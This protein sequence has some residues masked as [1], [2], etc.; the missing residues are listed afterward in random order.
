MMKMPIFIV[1]MLI[2]ISACH[3]PKEY[4]EFVTIPGQTWNS[5]NILHFNVNITDTTTAQNILISVRN[6]G[7]YAYS[8]LYLFVNA[9]S[10]NGSVARDTV[11]IMLADER[12]KWLG[13]GAAS[14]F[15]LYHPYRINIRFPLPGIYTFDIEQAMW[16]KELKYIH[17]IGLRIENAS[18]PK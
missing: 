1:G 18:L 12:G 4:E 10:P 6:S 11:E 8:N 16:T 9:H 17:D 15:T 2:V 5:K 3:N 7:K 13:R 14:I